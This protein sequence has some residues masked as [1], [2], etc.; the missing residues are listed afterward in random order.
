MYFLGAFYGVAHISSQSIVET[1]EVPTIKS[2]GVP[3]VVTDD[4]NFR[5]KEGDLAFR[6]IAQLY[7]CTSEEA[8]KRYNN[9]MSNLTIYVGDS[10]S[11]GED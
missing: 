8:E 3:F 6:L 4:Q 5:S 2:K 7:K 11:S 9:I 10:I 1:E